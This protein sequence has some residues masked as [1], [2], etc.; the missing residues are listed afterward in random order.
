MG[1]RSYSAMAALCSCASY[2]LFKILAACVP[3]GGVG[4]F[5]VSALA[6]VPG[7]LSALGESDSMRQHDGRLSLF[8]IR[9]N[10]VFFKLCSH[11]AQTTTDRSF[12]ASR[13]LQE[14]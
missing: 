12:R 9:Y 3:A 11:V 10:I 1:S 13:I 7:D 6:V 5:A 14:S 2:P 4:G 8:W